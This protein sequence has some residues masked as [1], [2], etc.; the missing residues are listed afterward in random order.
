MNKNELIEAIQQVITPNGQKGITAESLAN[1]LIEMV[2]ATPEGGSG[3]SGQ[4]VFYAGMPTGETDEFLAMSEFEP[5][6]EQKAHNVEMFK[7]IKE[8][9][10]ALNASM[11]ISDLV[12][13]QITEAGI[14]AS[15]LKETLSSYLLAYVPKHVAETESLQDEYIGIENTMGVFMVLSNGTVMLYSN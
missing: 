8:S 14:D 3:G 4:I 15:G 7:V 1:L 5:T 6:P 2:N 13:S 10:I 11:D 9:P 12:I